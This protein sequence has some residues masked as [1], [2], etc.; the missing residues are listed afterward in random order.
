MSSL[1]KSLQVSFEFF[2]PKDDQMSDTL[3]KSLKR[4]EPLE[5]QFVSVT[6]G[7]MG[8]TRSR[9]HDLVKKIIKE[10]NMQPAAHL[11]C[12]GSSIEEIHEIASKYWQDGV[13]HIVAL[14]GDDPNSNEHNKI[15]LKNATDLIKTLKKK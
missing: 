11:T 7:A 5:P 3:W 10:T 15:E 14:R 13:R 2:P 9:T 1:N 8:S 6:Y 12:V 4:L